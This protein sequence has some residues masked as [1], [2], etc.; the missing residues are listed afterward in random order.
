MMRKPAVAG[1]FYE[2][3][4]QLLKERIKW[5]YTH[6]IGPG[7]IP[8]KLGNKRSIK[9][10]ISPHAGYEFSGPV[11]AFSYLELAEDGLPETVLILCPNH[12]GMGSGLSTMTQGGWQT[13]LGE[14]PIDTEFARKLVDNYPLMDDE[15]SAHIQEH[16]CEVQLPFL[17]ELGQDFKLVPI[18]MMMQDLE[19]SQELGGAIALTA[20]ELGQDLVV[21]AS[22]DFTHQMPHK[23]AVAQDKKVLDAIESFDEQEMFKR[24]ISNNVTMCGYGPVA[25]TMAASKAMGA[26][27]ATILKYATSGDTSGNYTS[28]VGYG[29]AVFR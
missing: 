18:C 27:D 25:T 10:L 12:T 4:E 29:S 1:Y 26:H 19:T 13:P 15:P 23:V 14:V 28:V 20:Q 9:G 22:T 21:I 16:S 8:G 3:D 11:A 7:R 2:S 5:C 24:I 17:Q 6:P